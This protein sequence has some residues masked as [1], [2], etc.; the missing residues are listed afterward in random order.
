ML[1][2]RNGTEAL[3]WKAGG[4]DPEAWVR[5]TG[6]R[7]VE[8]KDARDPKTSGQGSENKFSRHLTDLT[9]HTLMHRAW[10]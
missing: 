8:N 1:G 4:S 2:D 3:R 7:Y 6:S 9:K 5:Q 10:G